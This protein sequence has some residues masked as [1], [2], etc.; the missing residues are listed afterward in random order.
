MRWTASSSRF[1][2]ARGQV[3]GSVNLEWPRQ[4]VWTQGCWEE[5]FLGSLPR[6]AACLRASASWVRTGLR[7]SR[8][9]CWPWCFLSSGSEVGSEG[10][11]HAPPSLS[12]TT[13]AAGTAQRIQQ[14]L[15]RLR[16]LEFKEAWVTAYVS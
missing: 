11:Q 14:R 8:T 5:P 6:F 12:A 3:E 1:V 16:L 4:R 7:V 10:G 13:Q 15:R 9:R 2:L